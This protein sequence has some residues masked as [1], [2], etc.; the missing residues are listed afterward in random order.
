[1]DTQIDPGQIDSTLRI[2][3]LDGFELAATLYEPAAGAGQHPPGTVVLISSATAVKRGY[4]DAYARH[5][6]GEGFTVVT[7]DYRGIG[8]SR[9]ARLAGFR[10]RMRDW[11]QLDLAGVLDWIGLHL[12]PQRLL[13]VGHSAGG[14][15]VGLAEPSWRISGLLTVGSQSGWWAHWPVPARYKIA[16]QWYAVPVITRLF[17]YLPGAFGT[18]E[19]LPA[20]VAREWARWGRR[21]R[22]LLEDGLEDGFARFRGPLFAYSF[23]DDTYAPRPAVESLL[24]AYSGADITHRHLSPADI[25]AGEIGHFGFFRERFRDSLWRESTAWLHRQE[26]SGGRPLRRP[27]EEP[28]RHLTERV[29]ALLASS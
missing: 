1:M 20:G 13:T 5:L 15:L 21:P 3:A 2:P 12:R 8:G 18:K 23:T 10:A 28:E 9:P 6:A 11:G 26:Q 4:Y 22:Y 14:Q 7:Y 27:Q 24:D 16:A 17:G 29:S 25:G 19:D